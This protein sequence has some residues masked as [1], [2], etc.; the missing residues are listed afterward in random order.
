MGA[1]RSHPPVKP[2]VGIL[3]AEPEPPAPVRAAVADL[4]GEVESASPPVRF[5]HTAYYAAE[6]GGVLTRHFWIFRALRDPA[7][8]PDWKHR[9]ND[10]ESAWRGRGGG[11]R[12]NLDP[13]YLAPG[14]LVLASTKDHGHRLYLRDGIYA[15]MTLRFQQGAFRGWPWTYPDY[16]AHAAFFGQAYQRYLRDLPRHGAAGKGA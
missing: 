7:D 4:F 14:K 13:G 16:L 12:V 1:V 2:L 9:L 11:R 6:M 10:V 3:S 15:E 8:L 5:S